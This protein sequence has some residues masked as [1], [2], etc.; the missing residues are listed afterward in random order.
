MQKY[1]NTKMVAQR[2]PRHNDEIHK[3]QR[4]K[5]LAWCG[6]DSMRGAAALSAR[7][8]FMAGAGYVEVFTEK[9]AAAALAVNLPE[10]VISNSEGT[11]FIDRFKTAARSCRSIL[12]GPGIGVS[13]TNLEKLE[14][15]LKTAL[16]PVVIDADA[17]TLLSATP[18][19]IKTAYSIPVITPHGGEMAKLLGLP[20]LSINDSREDLALKFSEQY[21][22][23]VVLKGAFTIITAPN[24]MTLIN[25][26]VNHKLATAGSGDVLAGIIAAL[27]AQGADSFFAA[28]CGCFIHGM[29]GE[30]AS[31]AG[32]RNIIASDI[33]EYIAK[34]IEA[35]EKNAP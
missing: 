6:S 8:A 20:Q 13:E 21:N 19:L 17:L 5:V 24:G 15:I 16:V 30:N 10:A 22:C 11:D 18:G 12:L 32:K 4:G 7:A 31:K 35:I 34:T 33:S 1:T 14:L 25:P 3:Y 28:V 26:H 23:V 29:A 2:L 9:Q 27:L